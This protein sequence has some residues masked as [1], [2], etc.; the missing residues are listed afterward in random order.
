MFVREKNPKLSSL[1]NSMIYLSENFRLIL[2][3]AYAKTI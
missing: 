2:L 1:K 3:K